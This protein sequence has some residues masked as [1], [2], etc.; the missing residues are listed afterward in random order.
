MAHLTGEKG[1]GGD[2]RFLNMNR[3]VQVQSP[4]PT[5]IRKHLTRAPFCCPLVFVGLYNL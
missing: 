2:T 3:E 5:F 1:S 4:L